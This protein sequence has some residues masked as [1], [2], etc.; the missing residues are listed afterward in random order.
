VWDWWWSTATGGGP[1]MR[2][3]EPPSATALD[4]LRAA[5]SSWGSRHMEAVLA[6]PSARST[7][8]R[9]PIRRAALPPPVSTGCCS[10][11]MPEGLVNSAVGASNLTSP[12]ETTSAFAT[13]PSR[14]RPTPPSPAG[15]CPVGDTAP[16]PAR[17]P[18]PASGSTPSPRTASAFSRCHCDA[19]PYHRDPLDGARR[20]GPRD[21]DPRPTAAPVA[22]VRST[23]AQPGINVGI[24][25]RR[26][27]PGAA[28]ACSASGV[29]R[30]RRE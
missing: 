20:R 19:A 26:D 9:P 17:T 14:V 16:A 2:R 7:T 25:A 3:F 4:V 1:A 27:R 23:V 8:S 12:T 5:G 11:R 30:R 15:T 22:S 24:P 29:L 6:L 13:T 10:C 18:A 21:R 28:V